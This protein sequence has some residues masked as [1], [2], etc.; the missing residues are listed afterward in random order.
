MRKEELRILS[1]LEVPH[2]RRCGAWE[3]CSSP[4]ARIARIARPPCPAAAR[5]RAIV[6]IATE[7]VKAIQNLKID[8]VT[9]WDSAGGG[10]NGTGSTGSFLRGLLGSL[11]PIR[12]LAEQAGV[13]LPQFLGKVPEGVTPLHAPDN[14]TPTPGSETKPAKRPAS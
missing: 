7:Q 10:D 11:P 13:D 6:S 3:R 9:V 1:H 14:T 5:P 2:D 12:E 8:K 4:L